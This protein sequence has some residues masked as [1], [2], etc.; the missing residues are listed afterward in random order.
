MLAGPVFSA[1]ALTAMSKNLYDAR[2]AVKAKFDDLYPLLFVMVLR[3]VWAW[4]GGGIITFSLCVSLS[5]YVFF[6]AVFVTQHR[7]QTS[8]NL[9]NLHSIQGPCNYEIAHHGDRRS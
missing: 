6:S 4:R 8:R 9:P 5:N 3:V 2:W 7:E 1:C